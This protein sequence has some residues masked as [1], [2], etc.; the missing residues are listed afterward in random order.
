MIFKELAMKRIIFILIFFHLKAISQQNNTLYFLETPVATTLNPA[1][2]TYCKITFGGLLLPITGQLIPYLNINYNNNSFSYKQV[3]HKGDGLKK[4]SLI[5]DV[6]KIFKNARKVIYADLYLQ[7]P[8]FYLSYMWKDQWYFS[9]GMNEKIYIRT[10]VPKDLLTLIWEGNGQSFLGKDALFSYLGITANW[11]REYFVG[12]GTNLNEKIKIGG[13]LKLL[14]GKMNVYTKKNFTTFYTNQEDYALTLNTNT[15]IMQS[16]P[17]IDITQFEYDYSGDSIK[18]DADT[19]LNL[20]NAE[21]KDFRKKV[22]FND[23]N[24]GLATDLGIVYK[25]NKNISVY[26]SLL[27][28]GFIRY[29]QNADGIKVNGEFTFDGWNIQPSLTK[30]DSLI[31]ENVDNFRDSV[32]KT[33]NP[34]LVSKPYN[35]WLISRFYIGGTYEINKFFTATLL[36]RNEFFINRLHSSITLSCLCKPLKWLNFNV[37]YTIQNNSFNNLGF[38]FAIKSGFLQTFI[39]SD[40]LLGF[41]WPQSARNINLCMGINWIFG[42]RKKE[43]KTL[44]DTK[45]I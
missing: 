35:Y 13:R 40:N 11:H 28:I 14:F 37:S 36:S 23:K 17:F 6:P 18:F 4:D 1:N 45:F 8:W 20:D 24:L 39:V 30:N 22:F 42:C 34:Q 26:A 3:I 44:L 32:I 19:T 7:I 33:F 12:V 9:I 10:N 15:I 21:F 27:D 29:R 16:Q 38:G 43:Y 31:E 2:Y 41:I 5:I 25:Y